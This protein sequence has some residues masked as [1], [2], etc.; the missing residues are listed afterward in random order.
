MPHIWPG[1]DLYL[2]RGAAGGDISSVSQQLQLV[3]LVNPCQWNAAIL[4][5]SRKSLKATT[6]GNGSVT[7][8]FPS[9]ADKLSL[10]FSHRILGLRRVS[11]R[12]IALFLMISIDAIAALFSPEFLQHWKLRWQSARHFEM[13]RRMTWSSWMVHERTTETTWN[14]MPC[15]DPC[16]GSIWKY[17]FKIHL[18][19]SQD[20]R[21]KLW[22]VYAVFFFISRAALT[23]KDLVRYVLDLVSLTCKCHVTVC[24][25]TNERPQLS[26]R[27]RLPRWDVFTSGYVFCFTFVFTFWRHVRRMLLQGDDWIHVLANIAKSAGVLRSTNFSRR[28]DSTVPWMFKQ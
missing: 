10:K 24:S 16:M 6:P 11:T 13:W 20:K 2:S 21:E 19:G 25:E 8:L 15:S 14:N 26:K 5:R 12:Q 22:S 9:Q 7:D 1:A 23:S 28:V 27:K 4:L 18:L 3:H 17:I